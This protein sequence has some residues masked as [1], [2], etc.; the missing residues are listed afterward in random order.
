MRRN[1]FHKRNAICFLAGIIP[2][3]VFSQNMNNPYS[4]YGIGDI[5]TRAYNRTAGMGSTGLAIRSSTSFIDNNPAAITGLPRSFYMAHVSVTGKTSRFSGDPVNATNSNGK[6]M[7]IKRLAIAVKINSFWASSAG[8]GQYS[9]INYKFSGS[10]FVEGTTTSYK[11]AF[12]GDGGLNE[13]YW[14]NAV[15]LGKHFSLGIKSS[16]IAGSINQTETFDDATLQSSISSKQQDYVGDLHFQA[17]AI[18]ETKLNKK[19]DFSI[20]GKYSPKTPFDLQ[21][22]LTISENTQTIQQIESTIKNGFYLP[23]SFAGGIAFKR[24]KKTTFAADYSFEDW[25]ALNVRKTGW[26]EV[27][28]SRISAG[29]EFGGLKNKAGKE[30]EYK[31]F[32]FGGYFNN[33]YLQVRNNPVREYGITGGMGGA[34]GNNL[35]YS[36]SLEAGVKGTTYASLIKE[37]Y[38]G[39]TL[40]LTYSDFL[41]SKGRK[42]E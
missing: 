1:L 14:T 8:F 21:R 27:S 36:L 16:L 32:Q 38:F 19:W 31:F 9:N 24:N 5:D 33:S 37:T 26:Q 2:V 13:F 17:G 23:Q 4:V 7:W 41:F 30:A 12:A 28:S 39:F 15:S 34:L 22:T 35:L 40:N 18:Y 42:Y 6:D 3:A 25:S 11:T 10:R 29:V 20:G